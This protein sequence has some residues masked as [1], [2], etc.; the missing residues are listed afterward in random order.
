MHSSSLY[1]Y[2]LASCAS[3]LWIQPGFK[4]SE[5]SARSNP[6]FTDA[7]PPNGHND[8]LHK[9]IIKRTD[10][11]LYDGDY[12]ETDGTDR[13]E[14]LEDAFPDVYTLI[15]TTLNHWDDVIFD[16][17]FPPRDKEK[18]SNVLKSIIKSQVSTVLN[19]GHCIYLW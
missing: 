11:T 7:N 2:A 8:S 6:S 18:V 12:G 4:A 10:P 14:L 1:I 17:W 9:T 16:H 5:L 13:K 15:I 3:A 19:I